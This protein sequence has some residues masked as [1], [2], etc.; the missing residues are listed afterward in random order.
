MNF[1]VERHRLDFPSLQRKVGDQPAAY[2]DGP[3]GTQVPR[4]VIAAIARYYE[5]S[6][7]N[8]HGP[9]V[10]SEETDRIVEQTRERMAALLGAPSPACISFGANMTSLAFA[11]ARGLSRLIAPGDEVIITDLDHEANRGPWQTLAERG[12]VI[13]SVRMTPDGQLDMAQLQ[14]LLSAKTKLVAVGYS[15]NSL[16]TVNDLATIREWSRAAGAWMIVDA[17]HYAPH[18]P[19]DVTTLDPDFLLCSAY[20]FYGPHV[21]ILYT[22]PGLLDQVQTDRLRPQ[23]A[24]SPYRIETGTLNFAALA[25]VSAAVDYLAGYGEG[26]TLRERIIHGMTRIHAYEE[27]LARHLCEQLSAI[28]Q[29]TVYG[30]RFGA[31]LRAPTVSFTVA[32]ADSGEVAKRLGEQGLFVWGGHF[33]A[34]RVVESL[35]LEKTGGLV[36]VGISLYNTREEIERVC[37]C[38][39]ELLRP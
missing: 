18:F 9:F 4:S 1:D 26:E 25:G 7:A 36:R 2:L 5:T 30:Q 35:G 31:G 12:A 28:P 13:H 19:V 17:V 33:Y 24:E 3:G 32:G 22:R 20:K 27:E 16:G 29:V 11:L 6:N 37:Q 8:A 15:S 34:M 38:V 10:T 21:G 14:S 39:E 23:S